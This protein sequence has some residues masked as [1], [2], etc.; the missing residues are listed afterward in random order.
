LQ[1]EDLIAENPAAAQLLSAVST[2]SKEHFVLVTSDGSIMH[3]TVE[4]R[5]AE[6]QN[7]ANDPVWFE[8]ACALLVNRPFLP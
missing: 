1:E 8:T 5:C 3:F 4:G 6:A 7:F 2:Y